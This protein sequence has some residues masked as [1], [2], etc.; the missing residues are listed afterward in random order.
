MSEEKQEL[1]APIKSVKG[2]LVT[3]LKPLDTCSPEDTVR[4]TAM[5]NLARN[6]VNPHMPEIPIVAP[7]WNNPF[8]PDEVTKLES[9]INDTQQDEFTL[10]A[11]VRKLGDVVQI[12]FVS[13]VQQKDM[14]A[15]QKALS[16]LSENW[17]HKYHEHTKNLGRNNHESLGNFES[18]HV[19]STGN[20][21]DSGRRLA[22]IVDRA[23]D[24][25]DGNWITLAQ[26]QKLSTEVSSATQRIAKPDESQGRF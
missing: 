15:L 16:A 18:I 1:S 10:H 19:S 9:F 5:Y 7:L 11:S 8:T 23:L 14:P 2:E 6:G 21:R 12:K 13:E 20:S 26:V 24:N 17:L 22:R 3:E 25:L 4:Y